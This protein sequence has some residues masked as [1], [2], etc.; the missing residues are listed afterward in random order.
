MP[1]TFDKLL[2][3]PLLH[4]HPPTT[5]ADLGVTASASELNI[6]DGATLTT[7]ELN[8]VDGV[9][10]AIQ[11]QIDGK[12]SDT[13][14]TMTGALT[15]DYA[16]PHIF[17]RTATDDEIAGFTFYDEEDDIKHDFSYYTGNDNFFLDSYQDDGTKITMF[18]ANGENLAFTIDP[19]GDGVQLHINDTNLY[20]DSSGYLHTDDTFLAG[21]DLRTSGD[22]YFL[23]G[24]VNIDSGAGGATNANFYTTNDSTVQGFSFYHDGVI[25]GGFGHFTGNEMLYLD[26]Y[27]TGAVKITL[28]EGNADFNYFAMF[29]TNPGGSLFRVNATTEI[30]G[31]LDHNGTNVGFYGTAPVAQQTGVAV[32]AAAIH[33]ALVSLGLITA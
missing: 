5:L 23:G 17:F 25:K 7:T 28:W 9:T 14:D 6:L 1:V 24:Q 31:D 27:T 13:G 15:M 22:G 20:R 16:Q 10:S 8:Y 33:A 3:K 21:G 11:T 19:F 29:P 2:G 26:S 12:V 30:N 4:S 18:T 32:T